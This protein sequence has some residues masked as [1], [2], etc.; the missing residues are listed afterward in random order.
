MIRIFTTVSAIFFLLCGVVRSQDASKQNSEPATAAQ[1]ASVLDLSIFPMIDLDAAPDSSASTQV[2]A[3]QSYPAKGNVIDV[4]KKIQSAILKKGFTEAAGASITEEYASATFQGRGFTISLTVFPGSKPSTAQVNLQNLGNVDLAKLPMPS[5]AKLL[6]A[7][8]AMVSYV[9]EMPVEKTKTELQSLLLKQGWE[10]FGDTTASFYVKKNATRMQVMVSEAPGQGGKTAIQISSEQLS[11]DLPVPPSFGFLQYADSTGGMIFDTDKSQEE[12]IAFFKQSLG[13]TS[14]KPTTE[15]TVRIGFE[16]HLIFRNDKKEYIEIKFRNVEGRTQAE[17]KY[18][19]AKQFA[20]DEKRANAQIAEL[21]KKR[22]ADME[23]KKN[24]PQIVITPLAQATVSETNK[25]SIEL[26]T[27]SG[28]AKAS[29]QDWMKSQE[30]QGW[31]K[32]ATID[33]KEVGDFQLEKDGVELNATFVDPGFI[34][35]SITISV[36][37]DYQLVFKK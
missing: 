11:V 24:P 20:E 14:W 22:E 28:A 6:Y 10:K 15:N 27:K 4:A 26:T 8:P 9:S 29:L 5:G 37:G 21:N 25:T 36:R 32:T 31:K 13:K 23:R 2:I 7:L 1:A 12:V 34:P 16:D 35:G 33:S 19:T 3:S 18:Q 17:L 30:A